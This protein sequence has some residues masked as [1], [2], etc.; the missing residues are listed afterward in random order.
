MHTENVVFMDAPTDTIFALAADIARWPLL[1]PHYRSVVVQEQSRDGQ[2]KAAV[3][4]AVRPNWPLPGF[5]FPVRWECVQ[6]CDIKASMIMF[7]HTA[8]IAQGM[9]V[10]WKFTPDPYGRRTRVSIAHDLR[11]PLPFLNGWFARE[12][13]GR[14]FVAAIAGR[15]LQTFKTLVESVGTP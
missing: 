9:W 4:R 6:V 10:V 5:S 2:R 12:V 11:Y 15:T 14:Q 1:L 8:G 7:K 3:M 13:V